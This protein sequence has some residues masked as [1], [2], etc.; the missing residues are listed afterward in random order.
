MKSDFATLKQP[1]APITDKS[2]D[3]PSAISSSIMESQVPRYRRLFYSP[4]AHVLFKFG[5]DLFCFFKI[6]FPSD[7]RFMNL[8]F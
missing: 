3:L 8:R 7:N 1:V 2:H 6:A 5:F 4:Q